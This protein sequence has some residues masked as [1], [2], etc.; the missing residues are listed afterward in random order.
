MPVAEADVEEIRLLR[1]SG[2]TFSQIRFQRISAL[3]LAK[4]IRNPALLD[5]LSGGPGSNGLG[6]ELDLLDVS[7]AC[8]QQ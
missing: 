4:R 8:G 1:E 6:I 3:D 5:A 2:V 7:T